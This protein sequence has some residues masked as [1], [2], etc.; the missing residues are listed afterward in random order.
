VIITW[1]DPSND[2]FTVS[3]SEGSLTN[4]QTLAEGLTDLVYTDTAPAAA[5]AFYRVEGQAGPPPPI[6]YFEDDF[7]TGGAPGW[8][9]V[10]YTANSNTLWELGAPTVAGPDAAYS[11]TNVY[12][13]NLDGDYGA[14]ANLCLQTP[15]I[16]LTS[17][18]PGA[19]LTFAAYYVTEFFVDLVEVYL[20]DAAGTSNLVSYAL[21]VDSGVQDEWTEVSIPVPAQALGKEVRF[22]FLFTS[23]ISIQAAGWYIDDVK[24]S[25]PQDAP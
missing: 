10:F 8:T 7:D 16:D 23:D 11:G 3:R 24:V 5:W 22:E 4:W 1:T 25:E 21:F 19:T 14:D 13:T 6:V 20:K 2:T 15:V 9:Q 18:G 12:A 17:A